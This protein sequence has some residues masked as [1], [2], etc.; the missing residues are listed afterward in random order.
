M[1]KCCASLKF[2]K[3][4]FL[5]FKVPV[6]LICISSSLKAY[7]DLLVN[8][9]IDLKAFVALKNKFKDLF[10]N[11]L[12]FNHQFTL[13]ILFLINLSANIFFLELINQTNYLAVFLCNKK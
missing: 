11:R 5:N 12:N 6:S 1:V 10:I 13:L 8:V 9:L 7:N 2:G 3:I 4:V